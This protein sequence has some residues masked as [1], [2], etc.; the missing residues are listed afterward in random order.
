MTPVTHRR[1]WVC[2]IVSVLLPLVLLV[3][4]AAYVRVGWWRM[5]AEC[6]AT[7]PGAPVYDTVEFGWSW[8]PPGFTCTYDDGRVKRSLWF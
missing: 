3:A 4:L 5:E 2:M 7:P 6:I 8:F 1:R